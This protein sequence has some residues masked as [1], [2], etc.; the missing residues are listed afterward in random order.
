MMSLNCGM[1]QAKS[2]L[3]VPHKST[4]FFFKSHFLYCSIRGDEI[5]SIIDH[6]TQI[7]NNEMSNVEV[8]VIQT[9]KWNG[10][11]RGDDRDA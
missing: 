11:L 8:Q 4:N 7:N 5:L 2:C 9:I 3:H 6:Q 1:T 10:E